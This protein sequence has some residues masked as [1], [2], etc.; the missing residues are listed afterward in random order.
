[1]RYRTRQQTTPQ[2][3]QILKEEGDEWYTLITPYNPEFIK[4]LKGIVNYKRRKWDADK[5]VWTFAPEYLMQVYYYCKNC[6]EDVIADPFTKSVLQE[7]LAAVAEQDSYGIMYL[8]SDAPDWLV[9]K[10]YKILL[11]D[12]RSEFRHPDKGGDPLKTSE[13]TMAMDKIK[14]G[15]N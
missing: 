8:K 10:V 7:K 3:A 14:D 15:G 9:E 11:T 4:Y 2:V 13:L 6:F 12:D 5:K 1:M